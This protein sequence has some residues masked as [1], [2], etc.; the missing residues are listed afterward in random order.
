MKNFAWFLSRNESNH[1]IQNKFLLKKND[2]KQKKEMIK[3]ING[4]AYTS[5]FGHLRSYTV[6]PGQN[7]TKGQIIG[8][9]DFPFC[10]FQ[11]ISRLLFN[12]PLLGMAI[13][14]KSQQ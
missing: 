5:E 8:Y 12:V 13:K 9:V 11:F 14:G 10:P 3:R 7:V 2:I 6:S 4:K 1:K